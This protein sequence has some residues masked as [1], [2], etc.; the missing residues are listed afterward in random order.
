MTQHHWPPGTGSYINFY[1]L[2]LTS[3]HLRQ[4][5]EHSNLI[6]GVLEC[7][8]PSAAESSWEGTPGQPEM[9]SCSPPTMLYYSRRLCLVC[10]SAVNH[11][12]A[13]PSSRQGPRV[14]GALIRSASR[15]GRNKKN[16]LLIEPRS[17][18]QLQLKCYSAEERG[19]RGH[20]KVSK[21][22]NYQLVICRQ[23][24]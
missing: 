3:V 1:Q 16:N 11:G 10:K 21:K 9:G 24:E 6:I 20:P 22:S 5:C 8:P 17:H 13:G 12:P 7:S 18:S 19:P 23:Q 2:F 14:Q 15:R 4:G